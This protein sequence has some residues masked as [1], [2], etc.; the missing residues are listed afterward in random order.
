MNYNK[1]KPTN[2]HPGAG[3]QRRN[4]EAVG[5]TDRAGERVRRS[6][7]RRQDRRAEGG[8][9]EPEG[10]ARSVR[11]GDRRAGAAGGEPRAHLRHH[12]RHL[13]RQSGGRIRVDFTFFF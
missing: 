10:D 5:R 11:R 12:T 4:G 7:P 8:G 13:F 2:R 3:R 9:V 6:G 1:I